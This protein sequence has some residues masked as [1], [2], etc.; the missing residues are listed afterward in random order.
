VIEGG[1]RILADGALVARFLSTKA[2]DMA[3]RNRD[4]DGAPC[5]FSHGS[6][7]PLPDGWLKI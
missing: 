6:E 1:V 4:D 3:L 5:L 2:P 7:M